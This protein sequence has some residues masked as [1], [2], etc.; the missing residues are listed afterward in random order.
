MAQVTKM[1]EKTKAISLGVVAAFYGGKDAEQVNAKVAQAEQPR[2]KWLF[3]FFPAS[4]LSDVRQAVKDYRDGAK[5]EHGDKSP[6]HKSA[7]Q[8]MKEF[9]ALF[10]AWKF[11]DYT[12][13]GIGYHKAV[14]GAYA[15]LKA[16]NIRA[17]G[18][19]IPDKVEREIGRQAGIVA[20]EYQAAEMARHKAEQQGK[21]LTD[22]ELQAERTRTRD[23]IEKAGAVS[24]A[25]TLYKRKGAQFCNWLIDALESAIITGDQEV[26]EKERKAA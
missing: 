18:A 7:V 19:G 4:D 20:A 25:S 3:S 10:G 16:K 6:Q 15:A 17:N 13:E 11:A 8:R 14:E 5:T 26:P 23:G 1:E 24:M 21:T 9:A 2:I 12:P 22:E